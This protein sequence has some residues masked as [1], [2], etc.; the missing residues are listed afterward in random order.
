MVAAPVD[1]RTK[2]GPPNVPEGAAAYLNRPSVPSFFRSMAEY[3]ATTWHFGGSGDQLRAERPTQLGYALDTCVGRDARLGGCHVRCGRRRRDV[4][5]P[6]SP[7]G[8]DLDRFR[9]SRLP[10]ARPTRPPRPD[11]RAG[12]GRSRYAMACSSV[13]STPTRSSARC[14]SPHARSAVRR[15]NRRRALT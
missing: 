5:C 9:M 12:K 4:R 2:C 6:R 14:Q 11:R 1:T 3:S 8:A 7:V 10:A 13:M 15:G